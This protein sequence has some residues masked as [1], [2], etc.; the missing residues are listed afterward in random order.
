MVPTVV[1]CESVYYRCKFDYDLYKG[2]IYKVILTHPSF[3]SN[4]YTEYKYDDSG[5]IIFFTIKGKYSCQEN[6]E[7][8]I[9]KKGRATKTTYYTDKKTVLYNKSK[10]YT[11]NYFKTEMLVN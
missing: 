1:H 3:N 7:Y 9:D 4:E 11:K 6:I 5:R 2:T 10:F 8:K